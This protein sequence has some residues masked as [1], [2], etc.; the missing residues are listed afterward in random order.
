M[1]TRLFKSEQL[2]CKT[3]TTNTIKT[4]VFFYILRTGLNDVNV[5][6]AHGIA[7]LNGRFSVR[8]VRDGATS[9]FHSE[10]TTRTKRNLYGKKKK[11][12]S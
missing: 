4:N 11:N 10:S 9:R 5:F 3:C 1:V 6:A 8:R 2:F 12:Q 7:D